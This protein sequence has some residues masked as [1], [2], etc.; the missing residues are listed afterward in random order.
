MIPDLIERTKIMLEFYWEF[1]VVRRQPI[2]TVTDYLI[3]WMVAR[4]AM[5]SNFLCQLH[6]EANTDLSCCDWDAKIT[7]IPVPGQASFST[8]F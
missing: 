8:K 6:Y 5:L 1:V 2:S 3:H 7:T 4:V